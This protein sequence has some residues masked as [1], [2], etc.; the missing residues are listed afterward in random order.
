MMLNDK[1]ELIERIFSGFKVNNI[2]VPV[3][4]VVYEGTES[5]Y[6][7]YQI[8]DSDSSYHGDDTLEGYVDYYDF[9]IYAHKSGT[10]GGNYKVIANA[11][12]N[13][14]DAYGFM[15]IPERSSGDMF[16]PDTGYYHRTYCFAAMNQNDTEGV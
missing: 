8:T 10:F 7:T 2:S 15:Y 16:E 13:L 9:D 14:L 5:T 3:A 1:N 12:K 4:F 11:I 6:I